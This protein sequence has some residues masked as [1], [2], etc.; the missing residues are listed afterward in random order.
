[1]SRH[2][3][4]PFSDQLALARRLIAAGCPACAIKLGISTDKERTA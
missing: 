4:V 1:M 3:D 2:P